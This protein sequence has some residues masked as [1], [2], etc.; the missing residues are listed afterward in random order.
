MDI[1]ESLE[2]LN[3]SE[4]CFDEIMGIV[5]E[6]INEISKEAADAVS[7]Q[8]YINRREADDQYSK[9]GDSRDEKKLEDANFKKYKNSELRDKWDILKGIKRGKDKKLH[10]MDDYAE[11]KEK[12]GDK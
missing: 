8:R 2:N 6:Y 3:V 1:F 7:L 4:K 10:S 5:E 12:Y 11:Y 9:T